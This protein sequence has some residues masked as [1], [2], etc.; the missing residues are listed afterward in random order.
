MK[1]YFFLL[2]FLFFSINSFSQKYQVKSLDITDGLS[3]DYVL[4]MAMDKYGF[5]WVA[6]EEGLNRFDGSRFY[7]YYKHNGS[8]SIT[9]NELNCVLDDPKDNKM[10]IG[11]QREGLNVFDYDTDKFS[12]YR[13]DKKDRNSIVTND[14]TS[15]SASA[16]SS[17]WVTTY[18]GGIEYFD[19]SNQH[20]IHYNK[21]N[22][23]GL[24]SNQA[25]S[26]CD[27]GNGLIY[28]GH[29]YDGLSVIDTHNR[30]AHNYK[31]NSAD[32]NSISGNEIH[33]IFRDKNGNIWIGTNNGLD[34]F[35]A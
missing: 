29:V 19:K 11:T 28:V 14:I 32:P 6:T 16:D 18:W 9:G 20:F 30:V 31:H 35:D 4:N 12:S 25:W 15:I 2:S 34:L 13:H 26:V 27:A 24:P 33:S 5:I 17:I 22:V 8:N 1:K 7:T 23:R 10:W 21:K 3:S